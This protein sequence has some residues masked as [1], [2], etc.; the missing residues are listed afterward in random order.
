MS[1]INF[2]VSLVRSS[3]YISY[4]SSLQCES[5]EIAHMCSWSV[6]LLGVLLCLFKS[7]LPDVHRPLINCP[8]FSLSCCIKCGHPLMLVCEFTRSFTI[9]VQEFVI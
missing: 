9:F 4:G 7:L 1:M 2:I 8:D 6:T 5:I 3:I